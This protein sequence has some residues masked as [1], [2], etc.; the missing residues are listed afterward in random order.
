MAVLGGSPLGLLVTRSTPV[1]GRSTF[2]GGNSRNVNV[3]DYNI[4]KADSLFTGKRI[5]RAW[6]IINTNSDG[7]Y[8]TIGENDVDYSK[9]AAGDKTG[10]SFKQRPLHGNNVYDTSILNI[11]ESLSGTKAALRPADF[12]YLKDVGVYPNNRLLVA[13]RFA[14]PI[15]DNIMT[16]KKDTE[17]GSLA[18]LISWQPQGTDFLSIDFGEKWTEADADFKNILN[19]IGGDFSKSGTS[20][21]G[22][23]AGGGFGIIPLPSFTE[24]FQRKALQSIGLIGEEGN[25]I[26]DE[27]LIPAGNP[28][29]IKEAKRRTLV[30]YEQ[31]GSGLTCVVSIS[32]VCEWE[33]KFISG[34]DPTVVWMDIL[35]M[36][37][38]FGTS[39]S[40]N[41][42]FGKKMSTKINE[43]VNNP[44][45]LVT[46][47]VTAIADALKNLKDVLQVAI[48]G[49]VDGMKKVVEDPAEA[50]A[51][52][53]AGAIT[54]SIMDSVLNF[55]N[56]MLKGTILKYRVEI[57]GV[58]NALTGNPSTPWHI[59]IG[60]PMR[61]IFCSGDMLTQSVKITLGPTLGF[62]DLPSTIKAE[63]TLVNA[64][65]W[66]MQEIMAKFNSGYL[67]TVDA[68]KTYYET[69]SD[70]PTPTYIKVDSQ[71]N[72]T[73]TNTPATNT[74]KL[75]DSP[76]IKPNSEQNSTEFGE[77]PSW[78]FNNNAKTNAVGNKVPE[79]VP[80]TDVKFLKETTTV[81]PKVP[82]PQTGKS[83]GGQLST[84]AIDKFFPKSK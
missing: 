74:R 24:I 42:G 76:L 63:F 72:A 53:D 14:G 79:K 81:S 57:L 13:R 65:S 45:N 21:L 4:S 61:P 29:L 32:M 44:N 19:R 49:I 30:G 1:N 64:R 15:N 54:N 20:N 27:N 5:V 43:W 56:T 60:N 59:T 46:Q 10:D 38:R 9:L 2:N 16:K 55:A 47:V 36:I 70:L 34:I 48:N 78:M 40:D 18:T 58:V 82:P 37:A 62:N 69:K 17:V 77:F 8:D 28:N 50:A 73:T 26:S 39:P 52:L 71:G 12:A 80:I 7:V 11:V 41:Y 33:M 35:A 67:R 6:P 84:A 51:K 23:G 68:Q 25:E 31:A 83:T 66:G 22:S 3:A 75:P